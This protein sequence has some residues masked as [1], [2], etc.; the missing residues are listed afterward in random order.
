MPP[1]H[2]AHKDSKQEADYTAS[3]TRQEHCGHVIG[4]GKTRCKYYLGNNACT[5][6]SGFI[7][8]EGW[9][10]HWEASAVKK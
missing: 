7:I 10:K 6:V 4:W 1:D 3:G 9:C 8:P 2:E 5:K